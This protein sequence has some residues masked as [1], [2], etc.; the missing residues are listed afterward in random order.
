MDSLLQQHLQNIKHLMSEKLITID[1]NGEILK[2]RGGMWNKYVPF[3]NNKNQKAQLK[4][5]GSF[6]D[7]WINQVEFICFYPPIN[8]EFYTKKEL[9]EHYFNNRLPDSLVQKKF[10]WINHPRRLDLNQIRTLLFLIIDINKKINVTEVI[11]Q[12]RGLYDVWLEYK[13]KLNLGRNFNEFLSEHCGISGNSIIPCDY[14]VAE[15]RIVHAE[16]EA[17][18]NKH[19]DLITDSSKNRY[20][21]NDDLQEP[22][23]LTSDFETAIDFK[24]S[25]PS[26]EAILNGKEVTK[27]PQVYSSVLVLYLFGERDEITK[28]SSSVTMMSIYTWAKLLQL[29][30]KKT[31]K[32]LHDINNLANK[33][34]EFRN[35]RDFEGYYSKV[36]VAIFDCLKAGESSLKEISK[37]TGI[38]YETVTQIVHSNLYNTLS[39]SKEIIK[40]YRENKFQ[41]KSFYAFH[42]ND[43]SPLGPFIG[44][45]KALTYLNNHDPHSNERPLA[46]YDIERC[47]NKRQNAAK[48]YIFIRKR[49]YSDEWKKK[50]YPQ[51]RKRAIHQLKKTYGTIKVYKI[52]KKSKV[53]IGEFKNC[54]Q[55]GLFLN[56]PVWQ[57]ERRL[58][59]GWED[60]VFERYVPGLINDL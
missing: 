23:A 29:N 55:V 52:I 51:K 16:I 21:N 38:S 11:K 36:L 18:I 2:W 45:N 33:I 35:N 20:L 13:N 53:F 60:Y 5:K 41:E 30:R 37:A 43:P 40:M 22:D 27:Y 44:Y 34:N 47:L 14:K 54:A 7:V 26:I 17:I 15:G 28:L 50:V 9:A 58:E 59:K 24:T 1:E 57:V 46:Y 6:I 42:Y 12:C 31:K 19:T 10:Y 56:M 25:K 4:F 48:G 32:L 8:N 49:D 3:A 39:L